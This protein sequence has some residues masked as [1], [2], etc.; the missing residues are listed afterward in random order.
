MHCSKKRDIKAGFRKGAILVD[1]PSLD[2]VREYYRILV[3]LYRNKV[4]TPLFPF[5]FFEKLYQSD[6][7]RILLI[8]YQNRPF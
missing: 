1:S 5:D 6:W 4:K 8:K 7:G 3:D 2:E